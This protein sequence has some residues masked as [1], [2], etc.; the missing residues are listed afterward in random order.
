M[1]NTIFVGNLPFNASEE[2]INDLFS[3]YGE[4]H[5]VN[6]ITHHKT[7]ESRGICFVVMSPDGGD[8]AIKALDGT[9]YGGRNLHVRYIKDEDI[10]D[11][12]SL[13]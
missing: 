4:V 1:E 11:T 6:L 7:G 5:S 9:E 8:K 10:K 13:Q 12:S 2:E 3:Q